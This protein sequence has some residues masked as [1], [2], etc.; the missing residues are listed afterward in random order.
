[1][2]W[3]DAPV[4][5]ATSAAQPAWMGAPEVGPERRTASIGDVIAGLPITRLAM[6]A[7]SPVINA[8]QVGTNVGDKIVEAT[9]GQPVVGRYINDKLAEYEAAKQRGMAASGNDGIDW[10]G[11]I[12]NLA[13]SAAIAK[14]IPQG[15]TLAGKIATGAKQGA[16]IA[17]STPINEAGDEYWTKKALQTGT[18][19]IFGGGVPA[20]VEGVKALGRVGHAVTEP[21][22]EKGRAAILKRYQ[23][24]VLGGPSAKAKVIEA[25]EQAR[26]IVPGSTPTSGE[27]IAHIPEATGLA[28]HQKAVSR[29][30]GVS[31]QFAA[32]SAEQ[33]GARRGAIGSVAQTAQ[34]LEQAIT[35][36][37]TEGAAKY[38]AA[39]KEVVTPDAAFTTLMQRP[40]MQRAMARAKE[41]ASESG[42]TF[43]ATQGNYPVKSLHYVKLALDDMIKNP[44]RFALGKT[45]ERAIAKTQQSFVDWLGK[46]S[47]AYAEAR[48]SFAAA[49]APINQM[50][51]GQELEKALTSAS[52]AT[53]RGTVFANA[54]REAPRT[55]KRATGQPRYQEISDVLTP[56]QT[57][58]VQAVAEELARKDA[59]TKL[60][61][62]TSLGGG[63]TEKAYGEGGTPFPNLLSRPAMV[64]N[65]LLKKMGQGADE[66]IH[67]L[68][69]E[70]YLHP[71]QLADALK[72]VPPSQRNLTI[73]AILERAQKAAIVG[74]ATAAGR[75]Y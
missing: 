24:G 40:S 43:E 26:E 71:Q 35:K 46:Q 21:L 61:G 22:Y 54:M 17:A 37:A 48:E 23:E 13:P 29:L 45:E 60:A 4:V 51:V 27:A 57:S 3:R 50:Q 73:Q 66:K 30:E 74:G 52:G 19:M 62:Q 14:A 2:G 42:E 11:L 63:M 7:A 59:Y 5:D 33:E 69:A 9:G 55:L 67:R 75:A 41:I 72:D 38:G 36:R 64:A 25:L 28:A 10:M 31:P 39:G 12:G 20:V 1:M 6:G 58:Q 34:D 70:Q 18:G 49:S 47:P 44:E 32:R 65:Y 8:F 16:A 53:E 56:A 68:A 15:V